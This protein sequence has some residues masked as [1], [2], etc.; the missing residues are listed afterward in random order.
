MDGMTLWRFMRACRDL[1]RNPVADMAWPLGLGPAVDGSPSRQPPERALLMLD[2][3]G[4]WTLP[5]DGSVAVREFFELYL[6][7]C[8]AT[9]ARPLTVAHLGQSLDGRIA[10]ESG[11]S[12]YVTGPENLDHLHRMR[13]LCDAV[14]VGA[15]TV[16]LDDPQLTTRR[17]A[18]A[19]P[20]R[21]ILDPHRRLTADFRV[22]RDGAA[23][24]LVF[25]DEAH[26]CQDRL[27]QAEVIGVPAL[28]G[29]LALAA[30]L[31][32]LH[33]RGLHAVFVEGGGVTV[34]S[35]LQAGLLD[36]LQIAVAPLLLG[37]GRPGITLPA[38]REL[39]EGLR[40]R[41]RRYAMGEDVLFAFMLK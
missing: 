26:V 20:V 29:R 28:G 14:I 36:Q 31:D 12:C 33:A 35:F 1:L 13:A 2:A 40:P 9:P 37:S 7:F 23:P 32:R 24:T 38:V 21:V 16:R 6:P 39:S 3:D 22:F 18:G 10:T 41:H 30:V 15:A 19:S 4:G 34:S 11:A 5:G 25:C 8:R 17:V 27:G